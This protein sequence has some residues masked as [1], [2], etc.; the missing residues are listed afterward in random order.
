M[1]QSVRVIEHDE[2]VFGKVLLKVRCRLPRNHSLQ[3]WV[4]C[5]PTCMTYAYQLFTDRPIL[6]WDNAPH[7]P[8][9]GGNFPHHF[10]DETGIVTPSTLVGE[11]LADL[12]VVMSEIERFLKI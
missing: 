6:R 4:H 3:V 11:P 1:V 8:A 7:H 5:E 12:P 9:V 10:H 2:T